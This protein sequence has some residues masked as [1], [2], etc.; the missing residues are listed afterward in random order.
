M[1]ILCKLLG[2]KTTWTSIRAFRDHPCTR[3]DCSYIEKGLKYPPMPECKSSKTE[4]NMKTKLTVED[5]KKKIVSKTFTTLPS[6]KC[7]VCEIMLKN[8]FSVR[9]EAAVVDIKN[10]VQEIG[11][12]IAFENAIKQIW[13]VEGYLL[14]EKLYK[15]NN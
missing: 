5:I 10:H 6:G 1:N 8:G 3:K 11:E 2:H 9:G 4:N 15:A 14:Q 13:I 7:I 12:A